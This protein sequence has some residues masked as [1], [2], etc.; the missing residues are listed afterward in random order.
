ML[1][2]VVLLGAVSIQVVVVLQQQPHALR[3]VR[4]GWGGQDTLAG[5][6]ACLHQQV[7][8]AQLGTTASHEEGRVRVG[9]G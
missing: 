4:G 5:R 6:R 2:V 1:A 7:D 8:L 9:R 3:V